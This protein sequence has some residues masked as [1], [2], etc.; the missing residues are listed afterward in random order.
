M[1]VQGHRDTGIRV[2]LRACDAALSGSESRT[3]ASTVDAMFLSGP[4]LG[5]PLTTDSRKSRKFKLGRYWAPVLRRSSERTR[6][7]AHRRLAASALVTVL[8]L[9]AMRAPARGPGP[10]ACQPE[11]HPS[12][13]PLA[14]TRPAAPA[15]GGSDS[16]SESGRGLV[17]SRPLLPR[18]QAASQCQVPEIPN[19][20]TTEPR[21]RPRPR[22]AR[23]SARRDDDHDN[24][25]TLAGRLGPGTPP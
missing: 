7:S 14:V 22:R 12:V 10:Q 23:C 24:R 17:C 18:P 9:T 5:G 21:P 1:C 25:R 19:T 15:P 13:R 20:Q 2:P 4:P 11:W 6:T 3:A 8:R 16:E